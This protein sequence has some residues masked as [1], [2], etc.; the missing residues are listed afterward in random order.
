[1]VAGGT[2][3][4]VG[5]GTAPILGS[6]APNTPSSRARNW[7]PKRWSMVRGRNDSQ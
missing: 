7:E 6:S 4:V 2:N 1:M 3:Y 5:T